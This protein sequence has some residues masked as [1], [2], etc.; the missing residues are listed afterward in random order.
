MYFPLKLQNAKYADENSAW[1]IEA[2]R[3]GKKAFRVY[4]LGGHRLERHHSVFG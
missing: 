1:L 2:R 4:V 3:C